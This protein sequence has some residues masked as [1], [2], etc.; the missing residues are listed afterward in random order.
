MVRHQRRA[1]PVWALWLGLGAFVGL[2]AALVVPFLI[3]VPRPEGLVDAEDLADEDS[4]FID[5]DGVRVHY[6]DEG[7]AGDRQT[8]VFLHG[9]ASSLYSWRHA[10]AAL[11][12]SRRVIAFDRPGFGLS[13]RPLPGDW[14]GESPYTLHSSACE[15]VALMDA[16]GVEQ[17][18][19]VGHSQG[20]SIAV[21]VADA[22]P[23][24]VSG[25][26]L[27]NAPTA[28]PRFQARP[29]LEWIRSIP[30]L[31]HI[32]PLV[33]RPFFGRNAK[34]IM[35]MAYADPHR[36]ADETVALELKATR[37]KDWDLSYV[38]LTRSQ[39]GLHFPEAMARI[40][41][42]TLVVAGRKD[43]TVPYRDQQ[44]AATSIPGARFMTFYD[45]GH[46]VP[47]ERPGAF[48]EVLEDFLEELDPPIGA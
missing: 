3:P 23:E 44:L 31:R 21:L 32:A 4:C 48:D 7:D 38:E 24:R 20:A 26:V 35:S 19:L 6:K 5:I 47:E 45:T 41:V 28:S 30:Q 40:G 12:A 34:R 29:Y 15:T 2:A 43:R 46:V 22:C 18:V 14:E 27:V 33:P 1:F 36:L 37:V 13:G 16:L 10:M 9:F 25:L 42:P 39:A 11:K 17:A 8:V